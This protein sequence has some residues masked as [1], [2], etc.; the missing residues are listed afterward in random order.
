MTR[1]EYIRCQAH[2][3]VMLFRRGNDADYARVEAIE[4]HNL[5]IA[6]RVFDQLM[7]GAA[8]Y[9]YIRSPKRLVVYTRSLRG[10]YV[11]V[12]HFCEIN[13]DI[14]PLSHT[15]ATRPEEMEMSFVPGKYI[16]W[17]EAA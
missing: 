14:V 9:A 3:S 8:P 13:G 10:N 12:S 2:A 16:V 6:C 11:Q 15:D 5:G 7:T 1:R 4:K 17:Q